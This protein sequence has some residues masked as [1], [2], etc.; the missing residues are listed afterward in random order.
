MLY[1]LGV[2]TALQ[3]VAAQ[4]LW[5]IGL[6]RTGFQPTKQFLLSTQ[7]LEAIFSPLVLLGIIL[8]ISA[9]ISFFALLSKFEYSQAQTIVVA[10]SIT[11][12]FLSAV[13]IFNEQLKF[14][15]MLGILCLFGGVLLIT[16]F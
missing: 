14:I 3:V 12:T 7:L 10:S 1:I 5:K 16:R 8:Y 9:T 2:I 13:V 4:T 6:E 11:F 15:N